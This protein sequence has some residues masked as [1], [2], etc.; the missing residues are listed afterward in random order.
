MQM[1]KGKEVVPQMGEGQGC[2]WTNGRTI[3]GY[4]WISGQ[5]GGVHGHVW[6]DKLGSLLNVCLIWFIYSKE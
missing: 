2:H 3:K 1:D 5:N 6:T 4:R